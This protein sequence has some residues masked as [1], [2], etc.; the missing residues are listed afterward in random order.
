MYVQLKVAVGNHLRSRPTEQAKSRVC[1]RCRI[2]LSD[3]ERWSSWP[4]SNEV[5]ALIQSGPFHSTP[6]CTNRIPLETG[7][8]GP[9]MSE[10]MQ[11]S[12]ALISKQK[13]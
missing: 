13:N 4:S 9:S 2:I 11:F 10:L 8:F 5:Q 12:G 6:S 3:F 1:H 7:H